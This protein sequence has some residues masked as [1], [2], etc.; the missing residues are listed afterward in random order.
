MMQQGLRRH[1]ET[2]VWSD[3]VSV[4]R[5]QRRDNVGNGGHLNTSGNV[6]SQSGGYELTPAWILVRRHSL[7]II[8][9]VTV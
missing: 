2:S 1:K 5:E 9:G 7:I 3:P 6:L 4:T 8:A